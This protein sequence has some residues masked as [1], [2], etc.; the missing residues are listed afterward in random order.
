MELKQKDRILA[1]YYLVIFG[2]VTGDG[3]VD[4]FDVSL[5]SSV[6]NY[7]FDFAQNSAEGFAGDLNA[8]GFIDSFDVT[9]LISAANLE[10]TISQTR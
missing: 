9:I 6:A 8:D 10:T 4:T 2:D 3:V 5:L 7:E 1:T